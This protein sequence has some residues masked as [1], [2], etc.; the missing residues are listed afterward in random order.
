[1]VPCCKALLSTKLFAG[2][3]P[4]RECLFLLIPTIL[5]GHPRSFFLNP[6]LLVLVLLGLLNPNLRGFLHDTWKSTLEV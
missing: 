3:T 2:F 5:S 4:L 1:M 6:H